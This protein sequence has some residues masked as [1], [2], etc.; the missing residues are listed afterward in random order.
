MNEY[1]YSLLIEN[2]GPI[3]LLAIVLW[4]RQRQMLGVVV[5]LAEE[6]TEVD[7][8]RVREKMKLL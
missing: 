6:H 3:G 8:E 4:H 1:I 5:T 7:E 2:Y